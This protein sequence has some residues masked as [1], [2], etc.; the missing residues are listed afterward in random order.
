MFQ[1]CRGDSSTMTMHDLR[2]SIQALGSNPIVLI[3]IHLQRQVVERSCA[4]PVDN[5]SFDLNTS[6]SPVTLSSAWQALPTGAGEEG[7]STDKLRRRLGLASLAIV[8]PMARRQATMRIKD[9]ELSNFEVTEFTVGKN[10]HS[11]GLSGSSNQNGHYWLIR[12]IW[13]VSID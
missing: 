12:E 11:R 4:L 5:F 13:I 8:V 2:L 9:S 10:Q 3:R 6:T 1:H 7:S